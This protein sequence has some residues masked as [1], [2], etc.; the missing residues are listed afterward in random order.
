MGKFTDDILTQDADEPV[1]HMFL[2]DLL[3]ELGVY[4]AG[5]QDQEAA[6]RTWLT[7]NT[8]NAMLTYNLRHDGWGYL[9]D[10]AKAGAA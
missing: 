8:P 2:V 4:H 9:L 6:L 5:A 7:T 10:Q 1:E 3:A